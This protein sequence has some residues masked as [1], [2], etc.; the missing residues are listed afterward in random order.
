[1]KPISFSLSVIVA[2]IFSVSSWAQS[3]NS[4]LCQNKSAATANGHGED[5]FKKVD[6]KHEYVKGKSHTFN[7]SYVV[8]ASKSACGSSSDPYKKLVVIFHGG[9]GSG[10]NMRDGI[11]IN[12]ASG[13]GG[14][15]SAPFV[16]Q[17]CINGK[18]TLYVFPNGLRPMDHPD[19]DTNG[20]LLFDPEYFQGADVAP[21]SRQHNDGRDPKNLIRESDFVEA[22][23]N[24]LNG[25]KV[26]GTKV[27]LDGSI[28]LA[29]HS[30]GGT[31]QWKILSENKK[32]KALFVSA[33]NMPEPVAD[34]SK[35]PITD[36]AHVFVVQGRQDGMMLFDGK[37][38]RLL[39]TLDTLENLASRYGYTP[40]QQKTWGY[41]DENP[42]P[43]DEH[44][45]EMYDYIY[46]KYPPKEGKKMI[47]FSIL[48]KKGSPAGDTFGPGHCWH[49]KTTTTKA[50]IN[51]KMV[52][53][54]CT[55]K[56]ASTFWMIYSF[57]DADKWDS[58]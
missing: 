21:T 44:G 40:S 35:F 39:S 33:G 38:G 12:T 14:S 7:R 28:Y 30:N 53:E 27:Q 25:S 4:L 29:G 6:V 58:R 45:D 49:G 51:G 23:Y 8:K 41:P 43:N 57:T 19:Y 56:Y 13:V 9:G 18:K 22:I 3:N 37:E 32:V 2:S 5:L 26:N 50:M 16:T 46:G 36:Q 10:C 24:Q 54:E 48:N 1:M 31:V 34:N 47:L 15:N 55:T 20:S 11:G 42:T 17:D 52:I